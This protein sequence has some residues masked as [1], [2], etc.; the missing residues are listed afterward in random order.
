[1]F[2]DTAESVERGDKPYQMRSLVIP[3]FD[4]F[5]T[6]ANTTPLYHT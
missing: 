6:C 1:M 4:I 3:F 5:P 2:G